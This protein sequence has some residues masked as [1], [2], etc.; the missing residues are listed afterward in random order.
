LVDLNSTN[1]KILLIVIFL[2]ILLI[3][4]FLYFLFL[5]FSLRSDIL[6]FRSN[7]FYLNILSSE[8]IPSTIILV[9]KLFNCI[10]QSF[11]NIQIDLSTNFKDLY[12]APLRQEFRF[13]IFSL[14][15]IVNFIRQNLENKFFICACI[16]YNLE[17]FLMDLS[18]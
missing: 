4:I 13:S 6:S 18:E 15:S 16:F 11:L 14:L 8:L 7:S 17:P 10:S 9:L 12:T 5:L 1:F 3:F 2:L